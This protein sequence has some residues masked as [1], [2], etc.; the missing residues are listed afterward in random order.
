MSAVNPAST[1]GPLELLVIQPTPFCNLDCSYCYLPDRLSRR[2]MAPELLD[3]VFQRVFASGL[4]QGPFTIIWHAG[5]P[6]V[7]PPSFYEE[8]IGLTEKY[9]QARVPVAQSFQ[10]NATLIDLDW[11]AFFKEHDVRLGVSVDGPAFLHDRCRRTRRGDGTHQRVMEGI[12]LLQRHLV[13][14]SVITVLTEQSL[15]YPDELYDFYCQE[16]IERVGFNIEEIEG[17]NRSSSL[18]GDGVPQRFARFLSRF[19]DLVQGGTWPMDVREFGI[20]SALKSGLPPG[21]PHTQETV[22]FAIL[23]VDCEGRFSTFSPELL[24]M[25]SAQY[26]DFY[27]GRV[28][29]QTFDSILASDKFRSIEREVAAGI[30]L[31]QET[32]SYFAWCGG[33]APANKYF[34]NGSFDS[35]ETLFCRLTKQT[36]LDV[37]LEKLEQASFH[38][39]VEAV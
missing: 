14:F 21:P 31:C 26:G 11:C 19:F 22:P 20:A 17:P 6:L 2:R 16:R 8:A 15:D 36:V 25:S 24:G 37:L 3:L 27:L 4:V 9:N 38:R 30:R 29:E 7:L 35:T 10:T 23:N 12:R 5:E 28:Q 32:C 1:R 13:P 39:P 18:Q 34:E 33:G